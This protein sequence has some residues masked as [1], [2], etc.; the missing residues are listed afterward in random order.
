MGVPRQYVE[1]NVRLEDNL[2]L[3][4]PVKAVVHVMLLVDYEDSVHQPSF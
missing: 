3:K 1:A 4:M 2:G